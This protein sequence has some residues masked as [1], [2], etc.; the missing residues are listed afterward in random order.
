MGIDLHWSTCKVP[1]GGMN[2]VIQIPTLL[3]PWQVTGEGSFVFNHHHHQEPPDLNYMPF[4]SL[5]F[6]LY[7]IYFFIP[8]IYWKILRILKWDK[9]AKTGGSF[10][11][12]PCVRK[13][14][15]LSPRLSTL[16][17]LDNRQC[18][19]FNGLGLKTKTFSLWS[20]FIFFLLLW[21]RIIYGCLC[22]K[23]NQILGQAFYIKG[24]Y[25]SISG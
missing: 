8:S 10:P 21:K 13:V 5:L 22:C 3:P 24:A 2:H 11:D 17:V 4:S 12:R 9:S 23:E 16:R 25:D 7:S 15:F 1:T 18:P 19:S 6:L 20:Q 14:W